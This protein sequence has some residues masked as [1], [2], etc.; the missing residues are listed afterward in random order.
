[1]D[2]KEMKKQIKHQLS[3]KRYAH[4]LRVT[5]V[6]LELAEVYDAPAKKVHK[7]AMLHDY[8][9]EK[10]AKKL[11]KI[12]RESGE[13]VDVL[14]YHDSLWHGPAA[15]IVVQDDFAV[16]DPSII[17][18]IR[19]HTTGRAEMDLVEQIVFI[20]DYIEPARSF[21]GI[22]DIRKLAYT[23]IEEAIRMALARTM[24]HLIKRG[25]SLH[26]KTVSAYNAYTKKS[27]IKKSGGN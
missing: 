6:A 16:T 2:M 7:A 20:A 27:M 19:Y 24:I 13:S 26:P 12:I 17:H 9:K 5:E 18:A 4:T 15:A 11:A 1:M 23:D 25:A 22:E 10:S 14:S 8:L 21:S 3:E